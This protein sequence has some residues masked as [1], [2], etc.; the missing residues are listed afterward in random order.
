MKHIIFDLDMTLI[1]SSIAEDARRKRIWHQV[2]SLIPNFVVFEGMNEVFSYI[3]YNNIKVCVVSNAPQNYINKV[4]GYFNIPCNYV[5]DYFT[6]KPVK[7]HPAQMY[8][9][10]LDCLSLIIKASAV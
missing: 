8:K 1:D 5:V 4:I 2:Y 9:V 7:P 6:V 10:L 3:R